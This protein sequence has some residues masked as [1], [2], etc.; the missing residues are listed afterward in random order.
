MT[1][2]HRKFIGYTPEEQAEITRKVI[3]G[4]ELNEKQNQALMRNAAYCIAEDWKDNPEM[5]QFFIDSMERF[6]KAF[7]PRDLDTDK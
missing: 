2:S 3:R 4:E 6:V 1:E 7:G 5:I